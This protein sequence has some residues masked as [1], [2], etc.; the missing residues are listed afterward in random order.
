MRYRLH[1]RARVGPRSCQCQLIG[2]YRTP[3]ETGRGTAP[4]K[5]DRDFSPSLYTTQNAPSAKKKKKS[6]RKRNLPCARK[7]THS[8]RCA[9]A[10]ASQCLRTSYID[11]PRRRVAAWARPGFYFLRTAANYVTPSGWPG[12]AGVAG[13]S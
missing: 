5:C 1:V 11:G 3:G 10:P 8:P 4:N 9:A 12:V 13:S 7:G 6:V 2:G